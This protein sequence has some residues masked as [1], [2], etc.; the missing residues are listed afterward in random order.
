VGL[1]GFEP[2][3]SRLSERQVVSLSLPLSRTALIPILASLKAGEIGIG[4]SS[5]Q[6]T[7]DFG[8]TVSASKEPAITGILRVLGERDFGTGKKV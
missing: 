2:S 8:T 7:S 6:K 1:D 4:G 5:V 3:T